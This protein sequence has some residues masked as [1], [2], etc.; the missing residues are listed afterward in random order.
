MQTPAI[1]A[2]PQY[3]M[4]RELTRVPA[5]LRRAT[6]TTWADANRGG[7]VCDCFLEGPSFDRDGNLYVTDIPH[8]R[9]FRI[10]PALQWSLVAE[11]DGWP[12]GIAVHPD[13]SLWI[14]DYRL[15]LLRMDAATGRHE[16]ILGHRN[17]ESFKGMNDLT[18]DANGNCYFTDQG[19]SGMHDPSGRVYRLRPGGQLDCVMSNIPSP[20]GLALDAAGKVLYVAVT[21]GN[22]I[23]RGPLQPDGSISKVAVFQNFF[24]TSGPDGLALDAE[25][26]LV[27]AHSSLGGVFRMGPRGN[28]THF[29]QNPEGG[30]ATNVAFRPGTSSLVY[31]EAQTGSIFEADLGVPGLPLYSHHRAAGPLRR[32]DA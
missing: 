26:G 19:Q 3:L 18:F 28:I 12:N 23:W 32:P 9:I 20:N 29:I 17:S 1:F 6:R 10:T 5:H 21:R 13:G 7:A 14:A 25:E 27:M 15:G 4:A 16:V 30:V 11:Y 31:T 24:G 2:P 22:S 8:G